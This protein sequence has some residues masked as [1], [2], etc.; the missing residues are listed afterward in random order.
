MRIDGVLGANRPPAP[1]LATP[2]G[3]QVV[4]VAAHLALDLAVDVGGVLRSFTR[5]W[6]GALARD[7]VTMLRTRGP[8]LVALLI[9]YRPWFGS[10]HF[11]VGEGAQ[12]ARASGNS[13]AHFTRVPS[14]RSSEEP[15]T[16][17]GVGSSSV[18]T[19]PSVETQRSGHPPVDGGRRYELALPV[20]PTAPG[21]ARALLHDATRAWDVGD[22]LYQDAAMV[23]TEMVANAV[24]HARTPSTLTLEIDECVLRVAVRD[25][26]PGRSLRALPFD[27]TSARGRG[28]QM[29]EALATAWGVTQH[30]DGKT[31]WATLP[32]D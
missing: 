13:V 29:I 20:D 16:P 15:T 17:P 30:L 4:D 21:R 6:V 22:D 18:E 7:V 23:V 25:G 11:V 24:D 14:P 5:R 1:A 2:G 31:V 12:A 3:A 9:R 26:R 27:P 32:R 8:E 10:A 28:L 19:Q